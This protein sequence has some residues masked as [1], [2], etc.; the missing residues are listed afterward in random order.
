MGRRDVWIGLFITVSLALAVGFTIYQRTSRVERYPLFVTFERLPGISTG[1]EVRMRGFPV[2]LVKAITFDPAPSDGESYILIELAID[3]AYPIYEGSYVEVKSQMVIAQNYLSINSDD[4]Q[5]V[6]VQPGTRLHGVMTSDISRT[7]E[8]LPEM[9]EKI[10]YMGRRIGDV[11]WKEIIHG[12]GYDVRRIR[13]KFDDVRNRLVSTLAHTDTVLDGTRDMISGM[14]DNLD[15]NLQNSNALIGDVRKTVQQS[16]EQIVQTLES[17]NTS[18]SAISNFV[19][20][21]DTLTTANRG[22]IEQ[23]LKN[24]DAAT[25]SLSDLLK[26]PLKT[27]TGGIK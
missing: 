10:T 19:V 2:G 27:F 25:T 4:V 1:T 3:Q 16:N 15:K 23:I 12:M 14:G 5:P 26:H 22:E 20:T 9:I 7:L 6:A 11:K 8:R 13:M 24:L 18:L 21:L 17:I